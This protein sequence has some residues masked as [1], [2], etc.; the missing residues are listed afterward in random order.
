MLFSIFIALS[1]TRA[2]NRPLP[3]SL[4]LPQGWTLVELLAV[5]AVFLLVGSLLMPNWSQTLAQAQL[6]QQ[7]QAWLLQLTQARASAQI[8]KHWVTVCGWSGAENC[9]PSDASSK[10]LISFVDKNKDGLWQDD[11]RLLHRQTLH[12]AVKITFNRG[13]FARF[14]PWGTSGQPGTWSL[15]WQDLSAGQAIV[16]SS[17]GNLRR[18]TEVC[19]VKS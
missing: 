15:C 12:N 13:N 1:Y 16:L 19:H 8:N 4:T 14:T 17:S 2:T 6:E 11:E 10:Q 5:L 9:H 3:Y 7:Q 18:R